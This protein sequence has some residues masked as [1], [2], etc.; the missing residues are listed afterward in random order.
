LVYQEV[1]SR[2]QEV[3]SIH[4]SGKLSGT[5]N[6]ARLARKTLGDPPAIAIVDSQWASMAL[7]LIVLSAARTAAGGASRDEVVAAARSAASRARLL[8]FCETLEY[9][10][11][12][13]RIGR[14]AAFLGGLLNVRPL[15]TVREGEVFPESRVRTRTAALDR[16][17]SWATGLGPLESYALLH[18]DAATDAAGLRAELQA[19]AP[20]AESYLTAVGPVVATHVGPGAVGIAALVAS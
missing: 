19:Y 14:A 8:L 7:G 15:I 9:L 11:K 5:L 13:G 16:L 10:Q 3:V 12:G 2:G 1:L 18:I 4:I 6:S 20:A 17:R